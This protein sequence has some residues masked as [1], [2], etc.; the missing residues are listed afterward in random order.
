MWRKRTTKE[1]GI[2]MRKRSKNIASTIDCNLKNAVQIPDI[3]SHQMTAEVSPSNI[4]CFWTTCKNR[5]KYVL[6]WIKR[7]L[8]W[9][10]FFCLHWII[11]QQLSLSDAV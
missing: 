10:Q 4:I 1:I 7:P 9:S 3:I 5:T 11:M 2:E 8:P 6:K